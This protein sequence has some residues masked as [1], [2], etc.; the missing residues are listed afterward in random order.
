MSDSAQEKMAQVLQEQQAQWS[1]F[2]GRALESSTKLFELN[3]KIARQSLQDTSESVRHLLAM[4]SPDEI[5]SIDQTLVQERL[6]HALEYANEIG[7]IASAFAY[8]ISQAA[9]NQ[10]A[11]N[12]DK[13]ARFGETAANPIAVPNL[14]LQQQ[15]YEQWL[16]AGKKLAE[17]FSQNLNMAAPVAVDAAPKAAGTRARAK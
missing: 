9:Q 3:L 12:L 17:T 11:G 7:A 2:A 14:F 1:A 8:E 16:D 10:M 15:G 4:K 5:F 13:V 6:N